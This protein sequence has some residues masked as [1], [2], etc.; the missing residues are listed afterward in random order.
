MNKARLQTLSRVAFVISPGNVY[1]NVFSG[2][3]QQALTWANILRELGVEVEFPSAH[4]ACNWNSFDLVHLFQVGSWADGLVAALRRDGIPVVLS[5]IIDRASPYGWKGGVVA[6]LPFERLGLEQRHR[7]LFR[8]CE[9]S[10]A[11][12]VRSNLEARSLRDLGIKLGKLQ[13]VRL[14]VNVDVNRLN[15]ATPKKRHVFHLSHLDQPRKNVRRLILA[16]RKLNV[17]LVLAGKI[18]D[19]RF[20][21]WLER[22]CTQNSGLCYLGTLD[23]DRKWE[24]MRKAAVFSLPSLTEGVGLVALEAYLAGANVVMTQRSGGTE[25]FDGDVEICDPDSVT[26]IASCIARAMAK[27]AQVGGRAEALDRLSAHA[28]VK[29][30]L[31]VYSDVAC[32]P[33]DFHQRAKTI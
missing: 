2:V 10:S 24:E 29:N 32:L 14:G 3:V 15:I 21:R 19:A 17:P 4:E 9:S 26:D 12:L 22:E 18:S 11:V 16:C 7:V 1:S 5:P 28:S 27:P 13:T 20:A 31:R 25:Y 30:L 8:H 6:R 33:G 23:E